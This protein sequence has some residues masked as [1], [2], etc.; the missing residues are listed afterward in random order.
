MQVV[1]EMGSISFVSWVV[2]GKVVGKVRIP[3][4]MVVKGVYGY[5]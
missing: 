3:E 5:F 2:Q 4:E 1:V